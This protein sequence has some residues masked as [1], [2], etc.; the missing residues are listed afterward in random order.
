MQIPAKFMLIAQKLRE[1][2]ASELEIAQLWDKIDGQVSLQNVYNALREINPELARKF[3]KE[4]KL[5]VW[6]SDLK[7]EHFN[8][9]RIV[10]SLVKEVNLPRGLAERIA[11]DV[12]QKIRS[13]EFSI[14]TTTLIRE[15][16]LA[17]LLEIS[18]KYYFRYMRLGIPVYDL[19]LLLERGDVDAI[20][21]RIFKQYVLIH[22][23]PR[24]AAEHVM[25]GVLH[26]KGMGC[27]AHP[28]AV[29]YVSKI[30]SAEKWISGFLQLLLGKR[31]IDSPS[32]YVPPHLVDD[33]RAIV[34]A[35][36]VGVF[37]TDEE[38]ATGG[39]IKFS[40]VPLYTFGPLDART[41]REFVTVDVGRLAE[42]S[43]N[44]VN[45]WRAL[46][47]IKEGV[48]AYIN[49]KKKFVRKGENVVQIVGADR[50]KRELL[51]SP[52]KIAQTFEGYHI[53]GA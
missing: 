20:P 38:E 52:D 35:S 28:Y 14:L 41:I 36:P 15:L 8:R 51:V 49:F 39:R 44:I 53:I 40:K 7:R 46:D 47:E 48:D 21:A 16:V 33:V 26:I 4:I 24:K 5:V 25:D 50:A 19:E 11:K 27:P 18:E 37:W 43:G 45:F 1:F 12:E 6:R 3:L 2:G 34:D 22:V 30:P 10:A 29:A 31:W 9:K 13:S 32:V 42:L 23:L 17:R